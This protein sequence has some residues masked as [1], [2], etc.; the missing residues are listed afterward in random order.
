VLA[1]IIAA[2][3]KSFPK[4]WAELSWDQSELHP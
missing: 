1:A 3:E 2:A 4:L